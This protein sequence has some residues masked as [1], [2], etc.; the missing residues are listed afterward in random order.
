MYNIYK[1]R[2]DGVKVNKM[3]SKMLIIVSKMA[4][5]LVIYGIQEVI[6]LQT[7]LMH[8]VSKL[9]VKFNVE[10]TWRRINLV[11]QLTDYMLFTEIQNGRQFTLK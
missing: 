11:V 9:N 1:H 6:S 2:I 7:R 5:K 8:Y 4:V 3:A 10:Q